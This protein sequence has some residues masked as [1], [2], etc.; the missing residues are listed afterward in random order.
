[1]LNTKQVE[2]GLWEVVGVGIY[3]TYRTR[4]ARH[5]NTVAGRKWVI[6]RRRRKLTSIDQAFWEV[7]EEG[8]NSKASAV[9]F[10]EELAIVDDDAMC[11]AKA[12]DLLDN[13][14]DGV[15]L[16]EEEGGE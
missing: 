12:R 4:T 16:D 6:I 7:V 11:Q 1:M 9:E 15:D 3:Y 5:D 14:D 8:F 13:I 10:I 2:P